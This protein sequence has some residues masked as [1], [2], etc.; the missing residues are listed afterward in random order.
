VN[1]FTLSVTLLATLTAAG[2]DRAPVAVAPAPAA[3]A[4]AA[5][6][7][8]PVAEPAEPTPV[9]EPVAAEPQLTLDFRILAP[10]GNVGREA[11][12]GSYEGLQALNLELEFKNTAASA[13]V[14]RPLD[15][16]TTEFR[17]PYYRVEVVDLAGEAVALPP[18]AGCKTTN[19]LRATDVIA[20][21]K[22]EALKTPMPWSGNRELAAGSYR[23]RV[24]YTAKRDP[25]GQNVE[26]S[27]DPGK[28]GAAL[29]TVWE[30]ELVSNWIRLDVTGHAKRGAVG[31]EEP[32]PGTLTPK[33]ASLEP[34]KRISKD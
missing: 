17:Y 25:K 3:A 26:H 32:A 29:K 4:A 24:H 8:A 11:T 30:G 18:L 14:M 23:A 16:S 2:C 7:P 6:A 22:G 33:R 15:G 5:P 13:A 20:L 19:P 10:D 27:S 12:V 21:A 31:D 9:A 28:A 34:A 1:R